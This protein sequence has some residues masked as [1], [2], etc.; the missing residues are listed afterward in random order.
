[1]RSVLPFILLASTICLVLGI[2]LPLLHVE[3]L[4]FFSDE[5]SLLG[6]VATLWKAGDWPLAAIIASFSIVFPLLKLAL[7]HHAAYGPAAEKITVPGWVR[8]IS[9]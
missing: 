9:N 1:M 4:Y 8:A 3:R 6:M 2:V 5:P 7:L